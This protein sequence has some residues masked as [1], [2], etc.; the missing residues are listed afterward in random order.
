MIAIGKKHMFFICQRTL[1]TNLLT[2]SIS[3]LLIIIYVV[4]QC[5]I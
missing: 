4:V 5:F 2:I 3:E 1:K